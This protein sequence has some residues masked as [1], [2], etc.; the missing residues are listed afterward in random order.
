MSGD[1]GSNPGCD[2]GIGCQTVPTT[3]RSKKPEQD[4]HRSEKLG[5]AEAHNGT[6]KG[7]TTSVA[8]LYHLNLQA[9]LDAFGFKKFDDGC[10]LILTA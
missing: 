9:P 5:A 7:L 8:D 6:A 3:Y 1:A 10:V 4:Q 2:F